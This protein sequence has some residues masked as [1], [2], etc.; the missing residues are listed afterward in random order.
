M[1]L[2]SIPSEW[3]HSILQVRATISF[4]HL[5]ASRYGERIPPHAHIEMV[6]LEYYTY[7]IRH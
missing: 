2:F 6:E 5:S 3:K 1:I 7:T 4:E